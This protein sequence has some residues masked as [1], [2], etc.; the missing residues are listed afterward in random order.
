MPACA[1]AFRRCCGTWSKREPV[2]ARFESLEHFQV[3]HRVV[4][5]V[6]LPLG[7]GE[8]AEQ[9]IGLTVFDPELSFTPARRPAST[10]RAG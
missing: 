3:H 7:A 4:E 6:Y 10:R 5:S 1:N 8:C 2:H 9:I